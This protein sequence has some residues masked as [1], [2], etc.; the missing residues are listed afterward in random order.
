MVEGGG[1]TGEGGAVAVAEEGER[2]VAVVEI[3]NLAA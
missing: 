1:V 3:G 2:G